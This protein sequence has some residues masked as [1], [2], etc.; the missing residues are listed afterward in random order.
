MVQKLDECLFCCTE[1]HPHQIVDGTPLDPLHLC[2]ATVPS[3][4]KLFLD[5]EATNRVTWSCGGCKR[6]YRSTTAECRQTDCQGLTSR[7]KSEVVKRT[8]EAIRLDILQQVLPYDQ[9]A[10]GPPHILSPVKLAE[11]ILSPHDRELS[12]LLS[13]AWD[14][15]PSSLLCECLS[16]MELQAGV[17]LDDIQVLQEVMQS[18]QNHYAP[19][20]KHPPTP[21]L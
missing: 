11:V 15:N 12:G 10:V 6:S 19:V 7:M 9:T 2:S 21:L 1:G 13:S 14:T 8:L 18:T 3:T 5:T 16:I 4:I 20:I 17:S